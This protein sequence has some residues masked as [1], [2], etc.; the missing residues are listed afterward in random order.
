MPPVPNFKAQ[1]KA[2]AFLPPYPD[3][4]PERLKVV[5]FPLDITERHLLLKDDFDAAL[6]TLIMQ[7]SPLA[8]WVSAWMQSTFRKIQSL[9]PDISDAELGLQLHDPMTVWYCIKRSESGWRL[10]HDEDIRVE[11]TGQW[12]RGACVTDG[13]SRKKQQDEDTAEQP[14]DHGDWLRGGAGNR[15]SRCLESPN[16]NGFG[17][18]VMLKSIFSLT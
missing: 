6:D 17:K 10:S 5:L 7:G 4:L 3:S 2:G 9:H 18:D 1:G 12:T 11:T 8:I 15:L 13:R 14:G 16:E